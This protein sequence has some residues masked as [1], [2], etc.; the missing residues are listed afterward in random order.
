MNMEPKNV[1][2]VCVAC[3]LS[4]ASLVIPVSIASHLDARNTTG[5][6]LA[7]GKLA[8]A[9]QLQCIDGIVGTGDNN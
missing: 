5:Q 3:V 9:Y 7:C 6:I 2:A 8:P 1:I 4:L